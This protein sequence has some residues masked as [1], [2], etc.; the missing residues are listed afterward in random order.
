MELCFVLLLLL[1]FVFNFT[2]FVILDLA[3][4]GVEK[5]KKNYKGKKTAGNKVLNSISKFGKNKIK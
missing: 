5:L 1:F 3:L 2:H 4:P